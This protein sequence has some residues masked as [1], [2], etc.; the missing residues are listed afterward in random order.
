MGYT[1]YSGKEVT[2]TIIG[3]RALSS[4]EYER[5]DDGS[6]IELGELPGTG[7]FIIA[8]VS[9]YYVAE[10]KNK[11]DRFK[12]LLHVSDILGCPL[13]KGCVKYGYRSGSLKIFRKIDGE[14]YEENSEYEDGDISEKYSLLA[15]KH[16]AGELDI[17]KEIEETEKNILTA[18]KIPETKN[19]G[20]FAVLYG[21]TNPEETDMG[22]VNRVCGYVRYLDELKA[23]DVWADSYVLID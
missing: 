11:N 17:K 8:R 7:S 20:P 13:Y 12:A 16:A 10:M 9:E 21:E 19:E 22:F 1:T 3:Y 14:W 4:E 6:T 23:A 2:G 15:I 18:K 5:I